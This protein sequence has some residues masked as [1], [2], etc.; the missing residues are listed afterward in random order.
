MEDWEIQE[1]WGKYGEGSGRAVG[2]DDRRAFR[3]KPL[4]PLALE[5]SPIKRPAPLA[6]QTR[7]SHN[8]PLH[9]GRTAVIL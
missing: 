8:L 4:V 9:G 1:T 6:E 7:R 5:A 3:C 2:D